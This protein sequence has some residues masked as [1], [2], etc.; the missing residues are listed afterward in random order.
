MIEINLLPKELQ[1]QGPR[2]ALSRKV[3][4]PAAG[5]LVLILAMTGLSIYQTKRIQ[6]LDSKI[7]IARARSEQLQRD[8]RMV[9]GLVDIKEKITARIDA[10][11]VLDRNRMVWVSVLEDFSV[12]MPEYLWVTAL[13]EAT[14]AAAAPAAAPG[15]TTQLES[16]GAPAQ[17]VPTELEGYAYSLSALANLIINLRKSGYFDEV[18]LVHAREVEMETHLAYSFALTC[19][20]NYS[21]ESTIAPAP[22]ADGPTHLATADETAGQ[23]N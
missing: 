23:Q 16:T 4:V 14:A 2:L 5:T 10:V 12:R 8:I 7:R 13:R 15:D 22:D 1:V 11:R 17:M 3:L 19:V 9:D 18:D 6:E 21:G 20:L